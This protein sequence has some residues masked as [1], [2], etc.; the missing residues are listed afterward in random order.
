MPSPSGNTKT[1]TATPTNGGGGGSALS[2]E[3]LAAISVVRALVASR[4]ETSNVLSVLR[5]YRQL[6]GD[7]LPYRKFGFS[8]VEEFLLAS[9]EFLIKASAGESTRIYIKPNRDS[10]HIQNMVAAQKT[11]KSG[12]SGKKSSFVALR[13]PTGPWSA[14]GFASPATA[15]SRIYQQMSVG[16]RTTNSGSGYSPKNGGGG[17]QQ[18][19]GQQLR[20]ITKSKAAASTQQNA[21]RNGN[22][23]S[24]EANNNSRSTKNYNLNG[25]G[26]QQ[27]SSNDLRHRLNERNSTLSR[28]SVEMRQAAKA[29]ATVSSNVVGV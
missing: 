25:G 2:E 9:G 13:Q 3:A 22:S 18:A 4:K 14:K 24:P 6:E 1:A 19:Q 12:G 23:A 27:L 7:P 28:S 11:T 10:A 16:G 15:Y 5:D 8:T 20:A 21:Q 17:Q 29:L 26:Q